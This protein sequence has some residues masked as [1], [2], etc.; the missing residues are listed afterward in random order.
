MV[1]GI[2]RKPNTPTNDGT[3]YY[4]R[5]YPRRLDY[6]PHAPSPNTTK[7]AAEIEPKFL[8][9]RRG[10][11]KFEVAFTALF[12]MIYQILKPSFGYLESFVSKDH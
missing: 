12:K 4:D 10:T 7:R 1:I 9:S 2:Y 11:F 6:R 5:I 8:R 3:L